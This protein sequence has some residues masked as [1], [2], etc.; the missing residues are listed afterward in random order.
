MRLMYFHYWVKLKQTEENTAQLLT[1]CQ[2]LKIPQNFIVCP[3]Q[4]YLIRAHLTERVSFAK[5]TA[6]MM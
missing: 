1:N 5:I 6:K 2:Q 3:H 4:N